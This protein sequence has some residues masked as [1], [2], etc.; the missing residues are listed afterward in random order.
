MLERIT[1]NTYHGKHYYEAK[2]IV[3]DSRW[4]SAEMF[5]SD[6]GIGWFPGAV[7]HR[8]DGWKG[9]WKKNCT[10]LSKSEHAAL[11][12]KLRGRKIYG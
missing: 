9:Y 6:M 4:I 10:W 7:L 8:K 2:G 5:I 1:S 3:C 12:N 11:H